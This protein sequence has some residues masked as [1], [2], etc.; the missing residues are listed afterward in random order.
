MRACFSRLFFRASRRARPSPLLPFCLHFSPP[1]SG[2]FW[3]AGRAPPSLSSPFSPPP[4]PVPFCHQANE[5]GWLSPLPPLF[6]RMGLKQTDSKAC[7]C[8]TAAAGRFEDTGAGVAVERTNN[9]KVGHGEGGRKRQ[10][11]A[12]FLR[13]GDRRKRRARVF[14]FQVGRFQEDSQLSEDDKSSFLACL[15][16][17]ADAPVN[18]FQMQATFTSAALV[19]KFLISRVETNCCLS[20]AG[21]RGKGGRQNAENL[22]RNV[23]PPV[24]EAICW[25]Q[26]RAWTSFNDLAKLCLV[27]DFFFSVHL[28]YM[29]QIKKPSKRLRKFLVRS[30]EREV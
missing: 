1:S 25:K 15:E 10:T 7:C 2:E 20:G 14:V 28:Q 17:S 24:R 3:K 8:S 4:S 21:G 18:K 9:V 12:V 26:N 11:L 23:L 19:P 22:C 16:Q 5:T 30:G 13:S 29:Q 27:Q 6:G